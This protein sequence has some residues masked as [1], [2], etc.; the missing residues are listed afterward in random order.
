M[1]EITKAV[2]D[3]NKIAHE[4]RSELDSVKSA[5]KETTE[6][7]TKFEK[8][9][10][11]M[12]KSHEL[13][14]SQIAAEKARADQLEAALKRGETVDGKKDD[15]AKKQFSS[16]M[17][18]MKSI[19]KIEIR[20]MAT[21]SNPD[22]GY[23]VMPELANFVA[24]RAFETSPL[25]RVARVVSTTSKSL[26]VTIDDNTFGASW[27]DEG[28]SSGETTTA[29]VGQLDINAYMIQAQPR[30]TLE[31]VQDAAVDIEAWVQ[32]KLARDFGIAENTAFVTGNGV[33]K[34]RGFL[35]HSHSETYA[36]DKLRQVALQNSSALTSDGLIALQGALPEIY[37]TNAS[38]AMNRT[39]YFAALALKGAD[40]YFFGPTLLADGQQSLQLL[41][42]QVV[43]MNDMP[44]V[45][46]DALAVAYGDFGVGYTIVDRVGLE[47]MRD[48]FTAKPFVVYFATKRVGGA[49]TNFDAIKIGKVATSV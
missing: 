47:I 2:E 19:D 36:R 35:T 1:S 3:L 12:V 40:N 45:A 32:E 30:V 46:A 11:D 43:F 44:A 17:R 31:M 6:W 13:I 22:G 33:G 21:D 34:P 9:A 38:W 24:T 18:D 37:Q 28:T 41:G 10:D 4:V 29:Q 26:K 23:L 20:A 7:K 15:A 48:P 27:T 16:F 5:T 39:T 25:R 42:K 49:V 8:M 14:Q